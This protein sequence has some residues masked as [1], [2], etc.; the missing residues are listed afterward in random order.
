MVKKK[1]VHLQQLDKI[2]LIKQ[3]LGPRYNFS[4]DS[5]PSPR[6]NCR[7]DLRVALARKVAAAISARGIFFLSTAGRRPSPA[8]GVFN[9]FSKCRSMQRQYM[10]LHGSAIAASMPW[11]SGV[12]RHEKQSP[13]ECGGRK[14]KARQDSLARACDGKGREEG[15]GFARA[16]R[17][18]RGSEDKNAMATGSPNRTRFGLHS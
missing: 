9:H 10:C 13:E 2:H 16:T 8:A 18:R 3:I 4:H 1:K 6:E 12:W 5:L 14:S 15:R 7:H 11:Q 17:S